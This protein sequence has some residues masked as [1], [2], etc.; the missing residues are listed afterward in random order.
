MNMMMMIYK[1]TNFHKQSSF[2]GA[3]RTH[4]T[5]SI[6]VTSTLVSC[7]HQQ[8]RQMHWCQLLP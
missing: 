7:V 2:F 1:V 4:K 3:P 5:N 6:Q 8:L